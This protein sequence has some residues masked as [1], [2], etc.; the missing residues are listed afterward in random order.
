[1]IIDLLARIYR[2]LPP[3]Y[4]PKVILGTLTPCCQHMARGVT[5]PAVASPSAAV[6][7]LAASSQESGQGGS[8]A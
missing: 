2:D 6:V 3:R 1:M 4:R 7:W 5:E 8:V